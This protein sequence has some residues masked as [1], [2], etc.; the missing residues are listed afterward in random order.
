MK[1]LFVIL[2]SYAS[3]TLAIALLLYAYRSKE[4]QQYLIS[5]DPHRSKSDRELYWR[6]ALNSA[7]SIVLI[8]SVMYG[9]GG[10]LYYDAGA[11]AWRYALEA[12]TVVLIYDFAYY[13]MHRYLFHEWKILR[14]VH[15]VHHAARNPRAIDSLLLHP[16]ETMLGLGLFFGSVALVG[17]VHIYTLGVLFTIYTGLNILNHAGI[18]VP[19]FPLKTLGVLAAKHDRH[20]HSMLSGNYAS[21]TP[22][23]DILF[24]T[25][26]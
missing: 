22:L 5:D 13:F 24:G 21:I 3:A 16:V 12:V 18:D 15:S 26:E 25:V 4:A 8:F 9:L 14:A 6:V 7:V 19:H 23:P 20:H 11:P 10:Y 2:A 1:V 17:G